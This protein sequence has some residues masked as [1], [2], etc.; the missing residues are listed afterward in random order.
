MRPLTTA[1]VALIA[2]TGIWTTTTAVGDQ[3]NAT[4]EHKAPAPTCTFQF[5]KAFS[6]AVWRLDHWERGKPSEKA[7]KALKRRLS[8]APGP[9]RVAMRNLW[10][11]RQ[12]AY[13]AHRRAELWRTRVTPFYCAG[14]GRW[15]ATDCTIPLHESG[16]GSGGGNLYGMLDAWALHGCTAFAPTAWDASK[17]AQDLCAHRHWEDYGRGGWPSY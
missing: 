9:H 1:V 17:R 15:W 13:F 6:E 16:Y 4:T 14:T 11:K 7:L 10:R 12:R 2:L 3:N 8:C 5:F